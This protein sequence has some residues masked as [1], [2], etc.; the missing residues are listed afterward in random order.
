MVYDQNYHNC[1]TLVVGQSTH[2]YYS[3]W[4]NLNAAQCVFWPIFVRFR[5]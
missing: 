4:F 3:T 5:I 1:F 2:D